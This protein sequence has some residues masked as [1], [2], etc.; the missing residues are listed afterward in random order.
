MGNGICEDCQNNEGCNFDMGDCCL[1]H[2]NEDQSD[3]FCH[4]NQKL[5]L[6]TKPCRTFPSTVFAPFSPDCFIDSAAIGDGVCF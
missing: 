3:C 4:K 6:P 2:C 1:L 5:D